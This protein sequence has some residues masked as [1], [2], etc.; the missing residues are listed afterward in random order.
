M[1]EQ[2]LRAELDAVYRSTSWRITAPLRFLMTRLK[3]LMNLL[4]APKQAMM[5]ALRFLY[6]YEWVVSLAKYVLQYFPAL[7]KRIRAQIYHIPSPSSSLVPTS[8]MI[9]ALPKRADNMSDASM[10]ILS[11]LQAALQ[12]KK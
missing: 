2:Q 9:E 3:F 8:I 10:Q 1:S 4:T 11:E 6:R 12:N 7:R 5:R